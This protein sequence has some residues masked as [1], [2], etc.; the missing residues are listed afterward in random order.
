VWARE[1]KNKGMKHH[2]SKSRRMELYTLCS[3]KGVLSQFFWQLRC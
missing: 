1:V 3:L 2:G